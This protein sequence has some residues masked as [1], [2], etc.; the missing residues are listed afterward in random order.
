ML[1]IK[2]KMSVFMETADVSERELNHP[3]RNVDLNRK[4][5]K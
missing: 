1:L 3:S 5:R 2:Q 4:K